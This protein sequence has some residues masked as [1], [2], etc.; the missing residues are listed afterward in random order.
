MTKPQLKT[1]LFVLA[2][3]LF[4]S[5]P[6]SSQAQTLSEIENGL[7]ITDPAIVRSL[8]YGGWSI[9]PVLGKPVGPSGFLVNSQLKTLPAV[10]GILASLQSEFEE[11]QKTHPDTGVGLKFGKRLFD[12]NFL[13][14]SLSRFALVG[15]VNRMDRGFVET[16]TCGEVRLIY[17]LAYMVTAN[18]EKVSS[19]LP[20]TLNVVMAA[21][22]VGS[23]ETC[24]EVAKRWL[25][26]KSETKTRAPREITKQLLASGSPLSLEYLKTDNLLRL[27]TNMQIVRWP[28]VV[29]ADFG[30]HAEYLLKVYRWNQNKSTFQ[31]STLENQIDRTKLLADPALLA[32]FK[33]WLAQPDNIAQLD[34]GTLILPEIFLAKK[35]ISTAPGGLARSANRPFLNIFST[36]EV[37]Q[38]LSS[39]KT[40]PLE[41][42]KSAQGFQRR[43]DEMTCTGCH[44]T[45]TVA[46][47]HFM[48]R[49]PLGRYPGNSVFAPASAHFFGDLPRRHLVLEAI[50]NAQEP[51][52]RRSFAA[53]PADVFAKGLQGSGLFNAW[54]AHCAGAD[55]AS[56]KQAIDASFIQWTCAKGL[57]CRSIHRSEFEPGMGVCLPATTPQVGDPTEFGAVKTIAYGKDQYL[58][59]TTLP[60][61]NPELYTSQPQSATPGNKT[62]GFPGS[63][64]HLKT[65]DH[66][67]PE[68]TCGPLP[69]SKDGFN[70]CLGKGQN[71][72][73]CLREFSTQMGL[74]GCD[75]MQ[76]C[77]DDYICAEGAGTER[78]VCVPPYFLF[79]FRVDGHPL[80]QTR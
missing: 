14:S 48:G 68:A 77:R 80:S 34:R 37:E 65:C 7:A 18:D 43:L 53:R 76:P 20:M 19:R 21:R 36:E 50:A 72:L 64:L 55:T 26:I 52:Y 10:T 12:M 38:I 2:L 13:N 31:E 27:E 60:M 66:L 40:F 9:G 11:Y 39:P 46:G 6:L 5:F 51:D 56:G 24:A 17:R 63:M 69:G 67:T 79:Q 54:G 22:S 30:G 4:L 78:G 61:P 28:A 3:G 23:T 16:K 44:Q 29:R 25:K 71:F 49:D 59:E 35:A 42:L 70:A 32:Q 47:F 73:R 62:G 75:A 1:H 74:R 33:T 58:R 8:E 45:R 57:V 15:V 41:F